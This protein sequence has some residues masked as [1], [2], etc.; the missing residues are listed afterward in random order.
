MVEAL[1]LAG[2]PYRADSSR[3]EAPVTAHHNRLA[4]S[5]ARDVSGVTG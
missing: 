2:G 3:E 5:A 1:S 4:N